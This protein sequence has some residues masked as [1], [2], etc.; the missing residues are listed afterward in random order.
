MPW[1]RLSDA[2]TT[3]RMFEDGRDVGLELV[4]GSFN[5]AMMLLPTRDESDQLT[6]ETFTLPALSMVLPSGRSI[7]FADAAT[8]FPGLTADPPPERVL[9]LWADDVLTIQHGTA[10]RFT[11]DA[12]EPFDKS[13]IDILFPPSGADFVPQRAAVIVYFDHF[14]ATGPHSMTEL[15]A[16]PATLVHIE[17]RRSADS[18]TTR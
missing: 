13:W 5:L 15:K 16:N 10:W 3:A 7:D 11:I 9:K 4:V 6:R 2:A 1:P 17:D 18:E 12:Q 8:G 14:P